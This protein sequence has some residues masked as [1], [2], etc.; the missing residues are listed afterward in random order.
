MDNLNQDGDAEN[1]VIPEE[2]DQLLHD[3][4][5]EENARDDVAAPA[6]DA[7]FQKKKRKKTAHCW[8]EMKEYKGDDGVQIAECKYCQ[9]KM[10]VNK[11]RTTTQF[12]RHLSMCLQRKIQLGQNPKLKQQDPDEDVIFE[13]VELPD[14]FK[15]LRLHLGFGDCNLKS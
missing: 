4:E 8:K 15:I 10:R 13:E 2:D 11:T 12:N 1:D 9:E 6:P 5:E 3:I 7:P 14:V